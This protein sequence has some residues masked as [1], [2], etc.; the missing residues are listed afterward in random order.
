MENEEV[1]KDQPEH[2]L[3][4]H[5]RQRRGIRS[6]VVMRHHGISKCEW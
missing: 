2:T 4:S 5:G 6:D 1:A 3:S